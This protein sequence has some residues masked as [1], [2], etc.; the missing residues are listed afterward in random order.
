MN[1]FES[2]DNTL[3]VSLHFFL[4][5]IYIYRYGITELHYNKVNQI[6]Y[7]Y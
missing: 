4:P 2:D 5:K 1:D 6:L 7:L 3:E